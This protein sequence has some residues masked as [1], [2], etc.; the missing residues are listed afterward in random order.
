MRPDGLAK[1]KGI[2]GLRK[3]VFTP[4]EFSVAIN[5][6]RIVHSTGE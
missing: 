5:V 3:V 6:G 4:E 2:S 1:N